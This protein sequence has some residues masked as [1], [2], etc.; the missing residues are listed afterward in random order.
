[1]SELFSI[2][3]ISNS[4]SDRCHLE[5]IRLIR[6][7]SE[8]KLRTGGYLVDL[9]SSN[10]L[11]LKC[12]I[13]KNTSER[14]PKNP[15]T[16]R[17]WRK[18]GVSDGSRTFRV[19]KRNPRVVWGC[20]EPALRAFASAKSTRIQNLWIQCC[21]SIPAGICARINHEKHIRF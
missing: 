7:V 8:L 14:Q 4:L 18:S 1:M 13:F 3:L 9:R 5:P 15:V 10:Q 19:R 12:R 20:L 21:T 2:G 11:Y 17:C 6:V 16:E